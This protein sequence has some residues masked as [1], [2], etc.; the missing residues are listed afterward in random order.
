VAGARILGVSRWSDLDSSRKAKG[1]AVDLG[2]AILLPGLVNAHCHLDYTH[3]A[4]Q[5]PPPKIFTDWL[6]LITATKA[7]WTISDFKKSWRAGAQMLLRTGTTTVADIEAVPRLLPAMWKATPLR[8][9]SF[10]EMIGITPRR[11]PEMVLREALAERR[12][13]KGEGGET[14]LSPH[15]PYSTVP[16]LLRLATQAAR[17]EWLPICTHVAESAL[18][19]EMFSR[20]T[21][22][23]YHWLKRSGR[24]MADC[25][26][27]SP[28]RHLERCGAL[29]PQLVAAH[30]NYLGHGDL[31]RL[32]RHQ[33]SVV[34]CPRSHFYFQHEPFPLERL[35]RAGVNVCLGTDSLASVYRRRNQTIE[36]DMFEEMSVLRSHHPALSP[37]RVLEMATI[38][39][40]RALHREGQIGELTRGALADLIAVPVEEKHA[41]PYAA[42]VAHHGPVRASMIGG[43][44]VIPPK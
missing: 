42:A 7:G 11:P 32:R 9:I 34:H 18:E 5:F 38:R 19:F 37:R 40:A 17:R 14:A 6:K 22:E 2:K 44:W 23:M 27:G 36:L 31:A 25:G 3:M 15:A 26:R 28:V 16:E 33:V 20:G 21:G 8:V 29:T 4:G 43:Q 39:A 13:L 12:R 30:V 24:D 41:D 1:S 10:L 35:A